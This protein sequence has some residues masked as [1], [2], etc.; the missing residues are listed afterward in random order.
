MKEKGAKIPSE[1][2]HE[3]PTVREDTYIEELFSIVT[4]NPYPIPV[5]DEKGKLLG[6]VRTDSIFETI[7]TQ[8]GGSND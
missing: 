7:S 1:A 3:V 6:V 2:I 8:E 5:T 4:K